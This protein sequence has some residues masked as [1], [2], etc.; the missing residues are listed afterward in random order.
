MSKKSESNTK[1]DS[2][3]EADGR[4]TEPCH[5]LQDQVSADAQAAQNAADMQECMGKSLE[6]LSN[7]FAA[8]ARRWEMIV[9]PAMAAFVVLAGYGFY[10]IY[11]L[12]VD[13][14]RLADR[15]EEVTVSINTVA[16][17]MAD[18]TDKM[19]LVADKMALISSDAHVGVVAMTHMVDQMTGM[20]RSMSEMSGNMDNMRANLAY[21]NRSVSR[22]MNMMSSFMPW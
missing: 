8:S 3:V 18:M 6:A 13:V 21:M 20:N 16:N 14:S 7:T 17:S 4:D 11:S 22:P 9:Y 1:A 10:L 19:I 15:M 5:D 2:H 12:T